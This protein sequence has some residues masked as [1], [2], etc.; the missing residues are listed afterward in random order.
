MTADIEKKTFYGM[1]GPKEVV[2]VL[3]DNHRAQVEDRAVLEC[4]NCG[5]CLLRCPVYDVVGKDFGGPAYLGGRGVAF[6]TYTDG[7]S[8]AVRSGLSLCTNCGLCTE[9]CPVRIDV[10]ESVRKARSIAKAQKALPT[11]EQAVLVKSVRNY[12]NPWMQP[13]QAKAKWAEGLH[14]R[15]KG[16]VLFFA[17]CSPSLLHPEI[18]IATVEILRSAGV[19]VAYLGKDEVCCGSTLLKIGEEEL[20]AKVAAEGARRIK[21]SGAKRIVTSCPGCYLTLKKYRNYVDDFEVEVEHSSQAL[22]RLLDEG[23]LELKEVKAE[24][25]FHDPC[26][27]GRL[28]GVIEE[29]RKV[30]ES[31]PG[32]ALREMKESGKRSQCCGSGGGVKTAHP[33]LATSIGAKRIA[34][35]EATGART[36]VTSCP[37]CLTNLRDSC[38]L[39][40]SKMDVVDLMVLVRRAL[41]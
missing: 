39:N 33:D 17:G 34:A 22:A 30:L 4:F 36:V 14:L 20:F 41:S 40:G 5:S 24:V 15:S 37:W 23:R 9:M 8:V 38:K 7:A 29:P 18:P 13:R 32:I 1:H 3:V 26:E 2:M 6:T 31:I 25:T 16:E 27:L 11:P 19:D 35:A 10:P 21:I 28:G 12:H